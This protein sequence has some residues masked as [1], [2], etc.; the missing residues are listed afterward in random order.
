VAA[1][2]DGVVVCPPGI[3]EGDELAVSTPDG[4][5]YD[6]VV[7]KLDARRCFRMEL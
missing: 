6:V 4:D 3:G 1:G 2:A 7:P 5:I